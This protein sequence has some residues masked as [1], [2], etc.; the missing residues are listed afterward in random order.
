MIPRQTVRTHTRRKATG[1]T[2]TVRQHGR[3]GRGK[4]KPLIHPRHA[5]K[6]AKRAIGHGRRKRRGLAL[7]FGALAFG[8]LAAWLTVRGLMF[9]LIT[10]GLV[11]IG[12]AMGAS[13]LS[14]GDL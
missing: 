3:T 9:A 1:G 11:A 5:W 2:T 12:V 8:E 13:M 4:K 7:A 14:G 10:L 6:N